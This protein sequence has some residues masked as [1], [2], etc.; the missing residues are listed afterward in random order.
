MVPDP[1]GPVT[2]RK[3]GLDLV[4]GKPLMHRE[5]D[6]RSAAQTV[7]AFGRGQPQV[8]F[9]VL[10]SVLDGI[11]RQA[12]RGGKTIHVAI[13]DPVDAF[14]VSRDPQCVMPV[15]PQAVNTQPTAVECRRD[16]CFP[17]PIY[18]LF[19][20]QPMAWIPDAHPHRSIR[21]E[22]EVRYARQPWF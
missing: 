21:S 18:Q 22:S 19:Q 6:D 2:R 15:Q 4:C 3:Y 17:G 9:S 20:A 10:E 14:S 12:I 16:E 8:T 7:D 5:I 1:D 11:A 13:V